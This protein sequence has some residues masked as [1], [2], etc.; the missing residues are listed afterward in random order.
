[1]KKLREECM[2]QNETCISVLN[3]TS[4]QDDKTFQNN[5]ILAEFSKETY[6]I[7]RKKLKAVRNL[8]AQVF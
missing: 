4:C 1:M 8:Q 3:A 7:T 5:F 2:Y 6:K